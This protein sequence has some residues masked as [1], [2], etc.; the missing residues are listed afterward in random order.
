MNI[1][2]TL[3][4]AVKKAL[5][6]LKIEAGEVIIE[7]PADLTNG[8]YS[9]N[10]ALVY[11]KELKIKPLEFAQE[12]KNILDVQKIKYIDKLEIAGT[13]FI[14]FYLSQEFFDENIEEILKQKENFGSSDLGKNKKVI[15]EYSSP[16]IAK[17]FTIGH[18]RSTIIGDSVANIL[19]FLGYKIIRDNHLGDWGTQFGKQI[20]AIKR[21]SSI[22]DVKNSRNLPAQAGQMKTLVDL[23]VKFHQETEKNPE[24]EDE[25]REWFLKLEKGDKEA[26][27]IYDITV[28]ASMKYFN[29]IYERLDIKPFDT[30]HGE[31]FYEPMLKGVLEDIEKAGIARKSE[32]AK[33]IF[34]ENE[35]YPPLMIQKKDGA[36]LYATRDLATDKYRNKEY[37]KDTLVINETGVEQSLYFKQIFEIEEM[38]GYFAKKNRVHIGHGFI[39]SKDGKM[40]TRKGNVVWLEEVLDE[41]VARAKVINEDIAEMVGIGAI[42][43]NDLKRE[44]KQNI[45]FDWDEIVNLKGD[46]G[47]YLQYSCV[48][49]RSIVAKAEVVRVKL[50]QSCRSLTLTTVL[51]RLLYRF[52]EVVYRAGK[53]YAPHYIA[54]Y[55]LEISS[56]FN[57]FY[58]QNKIIDKDDPASA[59]RVVLTHAF[60]IVIANGLNLLGIKIPEKM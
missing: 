24:L 27:E 52:P 12:I 36:T 30:L 35:K 55:L 10:V 25:A 19:Q 15:V 8:D 41:G 2:E 60:S 58:A 42:K 16:N 29:M 57:N 33:L 46:S 54:Q 37:G 14:N 17:P 4:N 22:E 39:R 26:K 59:Y 9:T 48:R 21:W 32:G 40:S 38:L 45:I 1:I 28:E 44:A 43:F 3:Q 56:A 50:L 23:Y 13:G 7:H 34:F 11:A 49:A 18:L 20:V 47:P 53:E 5:K 6:E 51:E 31:A